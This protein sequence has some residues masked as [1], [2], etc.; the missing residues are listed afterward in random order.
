MMRYD[1][2]SR[3]VENIKKAFDDE[4]A[5]HA[6]YLLFGREARRKGE[7]QLA[8]LYERLACEELAHAEMWL[9]EMEGLGSTEENLRASAEEERND[10]MMRYMPYASTA[11]H[12]GYEEL[13]ERFLHTARVE[14]RHEAELKELMGERKDGSA[15]R[16]VEAVEWSCGNC[17]Y[18]GISESAPAVCPLCGYPRGY[19]RRG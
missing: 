7:E 12:E 6:R 3:S 15:Y 4:A 1:K 2:N 11:D 17:G 8:R 9:R 18:V 14:K 10:W 16:S 5:G 19:F 13:S